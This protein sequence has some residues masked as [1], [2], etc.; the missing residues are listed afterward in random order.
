MNCERDL[1]CY[2][3]SEGANDLPPNTAWMPLNTRTLLESGALV[4]KARAYTPAVQR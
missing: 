2:V 4:M 3:W 1:S